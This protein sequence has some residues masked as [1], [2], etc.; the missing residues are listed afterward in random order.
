MTPAIHSAIPYS[1][2]TYF[3]THHSFQQISAIT[4]HLLLLPPVH[5]HHHLLTII[6]NCFHLPASAISASASAI[7]ASA[8]A[9]ST[10]ASAISASAYAVSTSTSTISTSAST[11]V[12]CCLLLPFILHHWKWN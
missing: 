9:I 3:P 8:S 5:C 6:A 7:S 4:I 2:N 10:S 11:T 1:P 12:H